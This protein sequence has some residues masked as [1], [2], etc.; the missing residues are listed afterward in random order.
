LALAGVYLAVEL[1]YCLLTRAWEANDEIDHTMYVEHIVAHGTLPRIALANGIESHQPPLYYL[2]VAAWQELLH[3]PAF[4]PTAE[5]NRVAPANAVS[6]RYLSL[7]YDY[8][9]QQHQNAVYLHELRLLSVFFG[10]ATVLIAYGCARLLLSRRSA[11]IC[12]GLTVALW[13]KLLVVDGAVTNDVLVITLSALALYIF[14]LSEK[15]RL[16]QAHA[17]RRWLMLGL[18]AVLGLAAITKY[19]CLPL[20]VLLL[21]LTAVPAL[22][23]LWRRRP[24]WRALAGDCAFAAAAAL[25]VSSWWFARNQALYGQF[26]ASRASLAYLKAWSPAL[27]VPVPWTSSARFVHFVPS[28]LFQTIWYDGAWNQ[29]LL[30]KWMNMALWCLAALSLAPVVYAL[31][32][33]ARRHALVE[34][35]GSLAALAAAGSIAAG[36]AAVAIIAKTTTQAQGRVAFIGLVGFA[37]VLVLGADLI[38]DHGRWGLPAVLLWPLVLAAVNAYVFVTYLVPFAGL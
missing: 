16:A 13:P 14:L 22:A 23:A 32:S 17:R 9:A 26:L 25:A 7:S 24:R 1:P 3:I 2:L 10:L 5:G 36:V 38:R 20:A 6:G 34:G 31:T 37:V 11:A 21:A 27:V 30:P 29:F 19:N 33:P 15:A 18:G 28:Q 12:A 35:C 4:V 8:T